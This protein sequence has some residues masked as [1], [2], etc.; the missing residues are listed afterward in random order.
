MRG[1]WGGGVLEVSVEGEGMFTYLRLSL[2]LFLQAFGNARTV[3]NNNSSRFGKFIL[4][5]FREN[6]GYYG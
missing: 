3:A 2:F 5:K 1:G 6:G 4:V